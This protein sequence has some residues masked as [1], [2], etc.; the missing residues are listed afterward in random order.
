MIEIYICED[1]EEQRARFVDYINSAI[2][3]H[4]YD[5]RIKMDTSNPEALIEQLKRSEN[6]GLYFLDIDLKSNKDGLM[7]AK[8]IR[9]YDPRGFIVFITSHPEM[10]FLTFQYKVEALDYI[11]KDDSQ[12]LKSQIY[13]CIEHVNKKYMNLSRGYRKTISIT[14]G[15]RKIA[16]EYSNILFFETSEKEHKIIVHTMDRSMEFFGKLKDIGEK[17]GNDFIRC[18]RAYLVNKE[19]IQ[20]VVYASKVIIMKNGAICPISH[21]MASKMKKK[22]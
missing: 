19:N 15:G 8:E 18:H 21:R 16:L 7:L 3:I 14:K 12:K 6:M 13:A 1:V 20:E 10:S 11:L 2:L 17:V 5:M 4:E 9:E 22:A